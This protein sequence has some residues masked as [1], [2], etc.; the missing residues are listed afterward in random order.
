MIELWFESRHSI[1]RTCTVNF[2]CLEKYH[3]DINIDICGICKLLK[4]LTRTSSFSNILNKQDFI[5]HAFNAPLKFQIYSK[6]WALLITLHIYCISRFAT[7][8]QTSLRSVHSC[9]VQRY[10]YNRAKGK[11]CVSFSDCFTWTVISL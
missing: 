5:I 7:R 8:W 4:M 11:K 3:I 6:S 1:S 2:Q 9:Q 10:F